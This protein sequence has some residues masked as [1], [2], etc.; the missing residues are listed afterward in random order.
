MLELTDKGLYCPQADVYIDPTKRVERAII[1]HGHADHA[2]PGMKNYLCH[3]L[4]KPI[5]NSRIGY[6]NKVETKEYNEAFLINGVKISLHNAA[7]IIGSAQVRLEYKGEVW[8]VSGDYKTEDDGLSGEF[9]A[10]PC[11]TFI[12]ESTFALPIYRFPSQ[13]TVRKQMNDWVLEN[14]QNGFHSV[15]YSYSLGK[16]QRLMHMLDESFDDQIVVHGSIQKLNE[17]FIKNGVHLRK[18]KT[19]NGTRIVKGHKP[20]IVIVPPNVHDSAWMKKFN[21][22][23]YAFCSGWMQVKKTQRW[24][25]IDKGFVLSD[26]ADWDGINQAIKATG[27][28][29]IYATHGFTQE[30]S[31]W[32]TE[33]L[34]L[35]GQELK[36]IYAGSIQ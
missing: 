31:R 1:T 26:H 29:T 15:F 11:H 32:V 35:N 4:T 28:Q 22:A 12:T 7:H 14:Q 8:V 23:K 17:A 24:Q 19:V 25:N 13:E 34:N 3:T 5:I 30:L 2:R 10:V 9:E 6:K 20:K 33:E 21:P 36:S 18:T 16:A 27:A